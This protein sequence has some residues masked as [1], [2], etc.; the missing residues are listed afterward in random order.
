MPADSDGC[1]RNRS[2]ENP[3]S[4][5]TEQREGRMSSNSL[6]NVEADAGEQSK[7]FGWIQSTVTDLPPFPSMNAPNFA[8]GELDGESFCQAI[9][10]AYDKAIT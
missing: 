8:W 10:S 5:D 2:E 9:N 1:D 6:A 7:D 3:V 4:D